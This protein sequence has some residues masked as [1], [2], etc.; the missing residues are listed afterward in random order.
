MAEPTFIGKVTVW[1]IDGTMTY[2]GVAT[3]DNVMDTVNYEDT[4]EEHELKDHKGITVGVKL[5]NPRENLTI[6]FWPAEPA[7]AGS[8]AAAKTNVVLPAKGSKVTIASMSGSPLNGTDW[9]YLG[10]GSIEES[11]EG[12]VKMTLPLRRYSTDIAATANS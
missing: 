2:T 5:V 6:N 8:I 10:G 7:G 1:G 11:H 3:T 9:L 12:D 4:V